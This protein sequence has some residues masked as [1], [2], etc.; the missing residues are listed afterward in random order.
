MFI[1]RKRKMSKMFGR[2]FIVRTRKMSQM[3]GRCLRKNVLKFPI[4]QN[5]AIFCDVS[6][7]RDFLHQM[8]AIALTEKKIQWF[9]TH[10][11]RQMFVNSFGKL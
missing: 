7:D 10:R 5:G 1:V 3:F 4:M 9:L 11:F 8:N 6:R 2:C